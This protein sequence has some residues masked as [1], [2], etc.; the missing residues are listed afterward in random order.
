MMMSQAQVDL[1]VCSLGERSGLE[2]GIWTNPGVMKSMGIE[3][4]QLGCTEEEESGAV[5]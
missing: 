1:Q 5:P 4:H 2:I 3:T